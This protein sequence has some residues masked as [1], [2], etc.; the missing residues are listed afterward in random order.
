MAAWAR[1]NLFT[2]RFIAATATA[3]SEPLA[4]ASAGFYADW[5]LLREIKAGRAP[6][7]VRDA[8]ILPGDHILMFERIPGS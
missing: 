8:E 5:L 2:K 1:R 4:E 7:R 3:S 6:Y